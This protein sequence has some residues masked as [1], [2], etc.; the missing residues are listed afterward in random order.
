MNIS[1]MGFTGTDIGGFA[2]Q[3]TGEL[4]ARWVQLGVFHP[5][6]RVHSSGHHGD[7][8][9]WSFGK[10]VLDI[11]RS[12]IELRYQ[13]L[14]Y[15]Y[16]MFWE[17][18][19][20]GT[21]MIKPLFYFDQEDSQTHFRTDEFIFGNHILV[22]PILEPHSQG[23]RMYIPRGTWIN[24]WTGERF[25]GGEEVWVDAT[26]ETIPIFIKEG[27][28]IPKYP[29]QQY[30][31]EKKIEELAID[32]YFSTEPTKSRI[33]ADG[34]DGYDYKKGRFSLRTLQVKGRHNDFVINQHKEG[35]YDAE[36]KTF[37][38]VIH[39]LPFTIKSIYVDD[40]RFNSGFESVDNKTIITI[41][42]N[43]SQFHITGE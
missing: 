15:L 13:L 5:F 36:Y 3:P 24:F 34:G 14:P 29:I 6:C 10:D 1:G 8:E 2:E 16:T 17:Y 41:D 22:C 9:P 28:C 31:G 40:Q 4:F 39:N 43:F 19:Q 21:P 37:K 11:V 42:K 38:L 35:D 7:Q 30:V 33:Y 32:V 20:Y 25:V 23:R 26:M 27:A 12:F 18:I